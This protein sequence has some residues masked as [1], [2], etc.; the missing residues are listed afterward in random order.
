ML[1]AMARDR[2]TSL[3]LRLGVAVSAFLVLVAVS[4]GLSTMML[5]S[6]DSLIEQRSTARRM[7]VEVAE[8]RLAFTDQETG[9][10]GYRLGSEPVFLEPYRNG[11]VVAELLLDRLGDH[12]LDVDGLDTQLAAVAD[13]AD[14]WRLEVAEPTIA[15][16]ADE[17]LD[18]LGRLRFDELRAE[19]E[20][21]A[22][23]VD[24]ELARLER[25]TDRLRRN[26]F[27]VLF[28]SEIAAIS[29]AVLVAVLFRRWVVRP[30]QQ[31][32]VAARELA[33][34]DTH[35]LPDVDS[36][37][38]RDVVDAVGSLQLSL[39]AARDE[40][41][42]TLAGLEQSAVLALQVRSQLADEIGQLPTGWDAASMLVPAEGLVAGDCF[43]VGLLDADHLYVIVIDVTGHGA[44]AALDALTAKSQLRAAIRSRLDPGP[45]IDWLSREM[46]K[47][48]HSELLTASVTIVD[49][50][51]GELR[52]ANA[53]HPPTLLVNG[54]Q[55]IELDPTGPLV[56]AFA[57]T[58][59]TGEA[60]L[61]PGWTL[62][63][64]TDGITDTIGVDRERFGEAR[65]RQSLVDTDPHRMID[66]LRTALD[67]FRIGARVDDSTAIAVHRRPVGP[68][69]RSGDGG[70]HDRRSPG[71]S[72]D[73]SPDRGTVPL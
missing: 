56:G 5:R 34:D 13:A 26:V 59:L 48:E 47:D 63:V 44:T 3:R 60:V 41:I 50:T 19:L 8:L 10:R 54:D 55:R 4:V 38:L 65:L 68:T 45:A 28:A 23:S 70:A 39:R 20:T 21:L 51:T 73:E 18:E 9:V 33:E 24:D 62:F 53:G 57:A 43:D 14:R 12:D 7:A 69:D 30:L 67:E 6:W 1:R 58:W 49:L 61:P 25:E 66:E 42:A 72:D 40:A 22:R 35:R 2:P 52:Y 16:S 37:E 64:H 15:G 46:L 29:A 27:G 31:L 32:S 36:A 71:P 17:A 11:V